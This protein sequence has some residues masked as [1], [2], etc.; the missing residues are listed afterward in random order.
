MSAVVIIKLETVTLNY[1]SLFTTKF[2]ILS[3]VMWLF[4][5]TFFLI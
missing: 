2:L 4:V 3:G 5:K 1:F